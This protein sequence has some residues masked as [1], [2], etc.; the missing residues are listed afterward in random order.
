ML[1]KQPEPI[2]YT[3]ILSEQQLEG[4][5][6][7]ISNVNYPQEKSYLPRPENMNSSLLRSKS[8]N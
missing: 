5:K 4:S 8:A 7:L 3:N 6:Y 2:N 1:E